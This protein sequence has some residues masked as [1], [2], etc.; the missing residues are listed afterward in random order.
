MFCDCV[1][2]HQN[3]SKDFGEQFE[4]DFASGHL[5][6]R[7]YNIAVCIRSNNYEKPQINIYFL[8]IIKVYY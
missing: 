7:K 8:F 2:F 5:S 3:P 6:N 4:F 1:S